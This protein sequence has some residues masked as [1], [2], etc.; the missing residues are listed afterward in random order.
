MPDRGRETGPRRRTAARRHGKSRIGG[1]NRQAAGSRGPVDGRLARAFSRLPYGR[2]T[3]FGAFGGAA[4]LF[5]LAGALVTGLFGCSLTPTPAVIWPQG[6]ACSASAT[7]TWT[8]PPT[9]TATPAWTWPPTWTPTTTHA[10]PTWT[11]PPTWTPTASVHATPTWTWPPTWPP[12]VTVHASPT[13]TWPPTWTPTSSCQVFKQGSANNVDLR[14]SDI[15]LDGSGPATSPSTSSHI[16][17][18]GDPALGQ[19]F[20]PVNGAAIHDLG[21]TANYGALGCAQLKGLIYGGGSA[22]YTNGE[23]FAVKTP[24][25]HYA[26]V[27]IVAS[28]GTTTLT[29][30][31]TT[32][33]P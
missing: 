32:Y 11:W 26:K 3:R 8:W 30:Q 10:T 21:T 14:N 12:T 33:K 23:V 6:A 24:G 9:W 15:N 31:W 20:S 22:P 27:Q 17:N 5:T 13:W 18:S 19:R 7:P 2:A 16:R 29:V 1:A 28:P 25:G 4:M